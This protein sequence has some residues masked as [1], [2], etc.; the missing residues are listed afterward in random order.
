MEPKTKVRFTASDS[1]KVFTERGV[2]H[3]NG[4]IVEVRVSRAAQLCRLYPEMFT[5]DI[6]SHPEAAENASGEKEDGSEKSEPSLKKKKKA[7]TPKRNR[8]M[9]ARHRK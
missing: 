4:A 2:V 5:T 3:Q 7:W 9:K 6:D 1:V 8:A